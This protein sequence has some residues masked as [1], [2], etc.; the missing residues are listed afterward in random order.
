MNSIN[1]NL[2]YKVFDWLRYPLIIGVVFIH[3]FG[4]E[5]D[6]DSINLMD[7][8]PID[9]YN[10]FRVSVS[11]VATHV[12]VPLFFIIS[13]YLF[14]TKLNTWNTIVYLTKIKRR[15]KTLLV[16]FLIWNTIA[17]LISAFIS[18]RQGGLIGIQ[19]FFSD[20]GY[21]HLYWDSHVWNIDRT[22]WWGEQYM[23]T[24][25]H[26]VPL[27]YLRDLMMVMIF[28]PLLFF[29]VV[30]NYQSIWTTFSVNVLYYRNRN[31]GFLYHSFL[32][33]RS[34]CLFLYKQVGFNIICV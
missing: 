19:E 30:K 18:F 15:A 16:P 6:Y 11:H 32:F 7:L 5:F 1:S 21:W 34:W 22:N 17:V 29:F 24:S 28:S 12:C 31:S 27:W 10:L 14:F 3:C 25:P 8:T 20:N 4:K 2:Q 9:F 26:L 33:F 13:G 23:S